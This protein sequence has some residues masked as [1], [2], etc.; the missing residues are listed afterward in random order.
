RASCSTTASTQRRLLAAARVR[1][2]AH[3]A[4]LLAQP[5]EP[6]FVD[7]LL[8]GA[9]ANNIFPRNSRRDNQTSQSSRGE[10]VKAK[11]SHF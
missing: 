8:N 4:A 9:D 10:N 5:L 11:R 7:P 3:F 6:E 2:Q 1:Y